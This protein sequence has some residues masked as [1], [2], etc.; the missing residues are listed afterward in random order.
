MHIEQIPNGRPVI[1]DEE[2]EERITHLFLKE[3]IQHP[4]QGK[5][6]FLRFSGEELETF[7]EIRTR[8]LGEGVPLVNYNL[9]SL[10][11]SFG[12]YPNPQ[13]RAFSSTLRDESKVWD[14][15]VLGSTIG[16]SNCDDTF[17]SQLSFI[18]ENFEPKMKR[19]V[20]NS[21]LQ[22]IVNI[23]SR[24]LRSFAVPIVVPV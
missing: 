12:A 22:R 19:V 11:E 20:S 15:C 16:S 24:P 23:N 21:Y 1:Q 13:L 7:L 9:T 3:H 4:K 6:E 10:Y 5:I 2:L 18:K 8:L 14:I 17:F